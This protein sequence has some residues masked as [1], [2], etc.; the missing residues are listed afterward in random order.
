MSDH[1]HW[2]VRLPNGPYSF[3]GQLISLVWSLQL[4]VDPTGDA[5]ELEIIVAPQGREIQLHAKAESA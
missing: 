3:S 4:T 5:T 2:R 1:R